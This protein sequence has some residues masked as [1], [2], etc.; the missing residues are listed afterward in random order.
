[1]KGGLV[2]R[3]QYMSV[4]ANQAAGY[5]TAQVLRRVKAGEMQEALGIGSIRMSVE[6]AMLIASKREQRRLGNSGRSYPHQG[7]QE[8]ARRVR[9][10]AR[11]IIPRDQIMVL[12]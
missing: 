9:Q 11:G 2:K 8:M 7:R 10:I 3:H 4:F 6:K 5:F 12:S 1:M